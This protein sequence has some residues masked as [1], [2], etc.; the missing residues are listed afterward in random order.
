MGTE[1]LR[2]E[3]DQKIGDTDSLAYRQSQIH[4][5]QSRPLYVKLICTEFRVH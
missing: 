3:N 4:N 5:L 1:S 2:N